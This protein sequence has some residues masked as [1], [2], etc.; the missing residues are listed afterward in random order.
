M[1][2]PGLW[3]LGRFEPN[4]GVLDLPMFYGVD[5]DDIHATVDGPLGDELVG[6]LEAKLKV[7]V[8]GD[9]LDLGYGS[10]FSKDKPIRTHADLESSDEHT[11]D[12]QSLM[13]ISYA[14]F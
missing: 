1:G 6:M 3:Q 4:A 14:V 7:K 13:R 2:V 12:I 8:I 11:S 5:R 10:I 9:L